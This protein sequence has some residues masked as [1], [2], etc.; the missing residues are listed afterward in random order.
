MDEQLKLLIKRFK[1]GDQDAFA[2]FYRSTVRFI[3]SIVY[4]YLLSKEET[5]DVVQNTYFKLYKIRS[6]V[7]TE[8]SIIAYL[9]K[10]AI[11]Y[12]I[13]QMKRRRMVAPKK[14]LPSDDRGVKE[15][16]HEALRK[17][18][19]KDRLVI[20]LHY[21]S[22]ASIKEISVLTSEREGAVKTRLFRAR[23][24]LREVLKDEIR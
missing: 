8:Q 3:Y 9:K 18:N 2:E 4:A 19:E 21:L 24:K 17:L 7:D 14:S 1:D 13:R 15:V 12:A 22:N 23:N 16:I 10:I 20:S 11:N 5:E 6:R